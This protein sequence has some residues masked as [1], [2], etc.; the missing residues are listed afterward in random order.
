MALSKT[1]ATQFG[2]S[3]TYHRVAHVSLQAKRQ[4]D[5]HVV[6]YIDKEARDAQKAP[7]SSVKFVVTENDLAAL[8]GGSA[9]APDVL[10]SACYF[11][12]KKQQMFL[13]AQDC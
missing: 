9:S 1:L 12:A 7:L 8:P 11:H 10:I 5:Y 4:L 6:S 3:A 2:V 13:G